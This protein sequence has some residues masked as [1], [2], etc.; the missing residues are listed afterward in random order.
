MKEPFLRFRSQCS[1]QHHWGQDKAREPH[2][3]KL[4]VEA[5]CS[6]WAVHVLHPRTVHVGAP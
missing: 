5:R 2:S 4:F 6:V 3:Y 1:G